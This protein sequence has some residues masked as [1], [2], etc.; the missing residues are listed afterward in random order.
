MAKDLITLHGEEVV[1]REDTAKAY[2]FVHWGVTTVVIGLGIMAVLFVIFFWMS[3]S[4]G[5]VESP[6]EYSNANAR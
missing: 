4:D 2:R 5:R 6:S 3:A 1:V